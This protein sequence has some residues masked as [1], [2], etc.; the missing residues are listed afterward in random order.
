MIIWINRWWIN[1]TLCDG[2]Q[3]HLATKKI[4]L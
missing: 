3:L 4:L 1:Q 2:Y